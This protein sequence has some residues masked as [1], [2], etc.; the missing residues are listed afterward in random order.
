[1]CKSDNS[2]I[3]LIVPYEK[4]ATIEFTSFCFKLDEYV[5]LCVYQ[6]KYG[7]QKYL[8]CFLKFKKKSTKWMKI[9]PNLKYHPVFPNILK[10]KIILSAKVHQ[11]GHE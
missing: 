1:M 2:K 4:N 11:I 9:K 5:Q 7:L 3:K 8:L 6:T 10:N